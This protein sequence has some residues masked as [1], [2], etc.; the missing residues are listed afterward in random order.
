MKFTIEN[1][2]NICSIGLSEIC[3]YIKFNYPLSVVWH[4][5]QGSI[6]KYFSILPYNDSYRKSVRDKINTN[7]NRDFTNDIEEL[8]SVLKPLFPIFKN[9]DYMLNFYSNKEKEFFQYQS[10]SDNFSKIHFFDLDVVFAQ[11]TTDV[12]NIKIVRNEHMA[13]LNENKISKKY[14]PSNLLDYT[15]EWIYDGWRSFF[16]TQPLEN[17][18]QN[19]VEYF[20]EKINN[21]ERPFAIIFNSEIASGEFDSYYYILDGHH[22]LMAYKNLGL[23][24]PIAIITH[25]PKSI[26]ETEFDMEKLGELLYPWQIEHIMKNND[27]VRRIENKQ[28]NLKKSFWNTIKK[29]LFE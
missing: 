23:Y 3:S 22:K 2:T 27:V 26:E 28:E 1:G 6:G 4:D 15:T 8:Y 21:G 20:Q 7:L 14:Y 12:S 13:F 25:L 17:I 10:S 9:G 5:C 24:P 18:D 19:R 29:N 16:A 11:R